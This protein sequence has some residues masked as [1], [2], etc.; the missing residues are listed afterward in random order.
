MLSSPLWAWHKAK[1]TVYA[2]TSRRAII[3]QKGHSVK[4]DSYGP[5][6]MNNISKRIRS[7]GSGD[8]IFDR[9]ISYTHS[10]RGG[11]R[12]RIKEIG[13]FG[14]NEVNHVEDLIDQLRNL[15]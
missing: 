10:R 3:F 1:K 7:D 5:E 14:I 15:V 4:I 6:E 12:E 2:L 9:E 13:F 11:T 8:L